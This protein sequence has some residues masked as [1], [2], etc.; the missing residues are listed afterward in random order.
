MHGIYYLA[1]LIGVAWLCAWVAFPD[2]VRRFPSPFDMR[3]DKRPRPTGREDN[4]RR[5]GAAKQDAAPAHVQHVVPERRAA[6]SWRVRG[7]PTEAAG[8]QRRG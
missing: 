1:M 7:E 5:A 2:V 8:R 6:K 3:D 4:W